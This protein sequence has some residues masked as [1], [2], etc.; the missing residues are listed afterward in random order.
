MSP[1]KF[2]M[3]F[4][5]F[6]GEGEHR[7]FRYRPRYYNEE[8]QNLYQHFG[9]DK[10][11]QNAEGSDEEYVPG[12]IIKKSMAEGPERKSHMPT[13]NKYLGI[14][15]LI[16]IAVMLFYIAKFWTLL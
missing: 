2:I 15:S 7:V 11:E 4:F 16:L 10:A 6:F 14:I 8:K 5:N 3:A 9:D 13:I 12:S 1:A